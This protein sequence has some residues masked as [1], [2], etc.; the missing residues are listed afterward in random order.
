MNPSVARLWQEHVAADF[1]VRLRGVELAGIDMVLLD[2]DIAGCVSAW[3]NGDGSLDAER[4]R[5]L[6]RCIAD[7]NTILPLL[8]DEDDHRYYARLHRLAALLS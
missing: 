7:L 2:A 3:R 5:I 6:R 1:P 8:T 4:H